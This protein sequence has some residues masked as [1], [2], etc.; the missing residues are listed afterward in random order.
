MFVVAKYP[1]SHKKHSSLVNIVI[2]W[3]SVTTMV[4]QTDNIVQALIILM[5]VPTLKHQ[6]K[7]TILNK[8][9]K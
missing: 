2:G 6:E 5:P 3:L 7:T 1:A 8:N 4:T 9:E